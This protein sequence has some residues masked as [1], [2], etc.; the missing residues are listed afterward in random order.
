MAKKSKK[1]KSLMLA[2]SASL[3]IPLAACGGGD[4]QSKAG[5]DDVTKLVWYHVGTKPK[6]LDYVLEEVNKYTTEKIGATI[7]L[8][9]VDWGDYNSKMQVVISSGEEYDIAMTSKDYNYAVNAQK[10]AFVGLNDL[11]DKHAKEAKAGIDPTYFEGATIDGELYGFPTNANIAGE[12]GWSFNKD[13]LDQ[14][15]ID[16]SDVRDLQSL[17]PALKAFKEQNKVET[18]MA[19]S[20]TFKLYAP[21]E[22]ILGDNL[23]FAV[24]LYENTDKIVSIYDLPE[25]QET[26]KT[27]HK[28]YNAGYVSKDAATSINDPYPLTSNNWFM[29]KETLGTYADVALSRI[30]KFPIESKA[31]SDRVKTTNSAT[32][33]LQAISTTSKNKE[34]A[35]EFLNLLNTDEKLANML[36]YG[37]EGEHFELDGD[38][39]ITMLDRSSDY[40]MPGWAMMNQDVLY[41]D[42][43]LPEDYREKSKEF[44][45][46]AIVSPALG[47]IFDTKSV[48]SEV[49]AVQ[50]VISQYQSSLHTGTVDPMKYIPEM[51]KKLEK[52]GMKKI[53]NEMQTQYDAW[54][55]EK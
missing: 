23:P 47:F 30:A 54:R 17:E 49:A 20:S 16:I 33:S 44:K 50:N 24:H 12:E 31:M 53:M 38:K 40:V 10:G 2:M 51:N 27:M 7:D 43:N 11:M 37:I 13:Y 36:A 14:Y 29:R 15:G 22:Y 21:V 1:M 48:R 34:K 19:A 46:T 3:M 26:L 25:F 52:A 55:A 9:M 42:K 28:Y 41:L 45:E 32:M 18:P 5:K 35:M 8:R 6:D 39:R 4:D